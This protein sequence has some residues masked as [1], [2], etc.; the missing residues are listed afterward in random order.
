MFK[1]KAKYASQVSMA[2][3]LLILLH[4]LTMNCLFSGTDCSANGKMT[5]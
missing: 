5:S 2:V 1:Y 3:N 4:H